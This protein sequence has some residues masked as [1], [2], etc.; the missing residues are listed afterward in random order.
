LDLWSPAMDPVVPARDPSE[1]RCCLGATARGCR[2]SP[3]ELAGGLAAQLAV[4]VAAAAPS[5]PWLAH[6]GG[7][8]PLRQLA[9]GWVRACVAGPAAASAHRCC[10]GVGGVSGLRACAADA[11]KAGSGAREVGGL[12]VPAS[13]AST[14]WSRAIA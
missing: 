8:R 14:G 3:P 12:R 1:V 2:G 7:G 11:Q 4:K 9:Y 13:E 10:S 6:G 5:C